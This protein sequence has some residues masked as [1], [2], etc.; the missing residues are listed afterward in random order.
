MIPCWHLCGS[1][2]LC[3]F[4][5]AFDYFG[6]GLLLVVF[7]SLYL[8]HST[9]SARSV[10]SALRLLPC[11]SEVAGAL[12]LMMSL[13]SQVSPVGSPGCKLF[14]FQGLLGLMF[15]QWLSIGL[16]AAAPCTTCSATPVMSVGDSCTTARVAGLMGVIV[17]A[18][19]LGN[20]GFVCTPCW[21]S[22][23]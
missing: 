10:N 2:H 14:C 3:L 19:V 18:G 13:Q 7:K 17:T 8:Q 6:L 5:Y 16:D 23:C 22:W 4:G 11:V 9:A 12:L 21:W 20:Q 1:S 15:L